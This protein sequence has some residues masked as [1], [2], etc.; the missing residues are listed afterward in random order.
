M[1]EA[2]S[3]VLPGLVIRQDAKTL[4]SEDIW[5][6]PKGKKMLGLLLKYIDPSKTLD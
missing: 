6:E 3:A 4:T 5:V 2:V 1:H